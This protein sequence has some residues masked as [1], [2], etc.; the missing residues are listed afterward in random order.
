MSSKQKLKEGVVDPV[1]EAGAYEDKFEFTLMRM[2]REYAE[3]H[4]VSYSDAAVAVEPVYSR[5]MCTVRNLTYNSEQIIASDSK[6]LPAQR[7]VKIE[8]YKL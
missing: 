7:A 6:G 2:I 3:E 8:G 1:L 5:T 4:D